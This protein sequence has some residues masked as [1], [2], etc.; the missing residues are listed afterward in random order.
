MIKDVIFRNPKQ[1]ICSDLVTITKLR[2]WIK[3][4]TSIAL[5]KPTESVGRSATLTIPE[6]EQSKAAVL[7]FAR[8]SALPA[9][10]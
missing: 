8:F 7:E 3:G 9:E 6:L 5:R 4:A 10:L 2:M 1:L